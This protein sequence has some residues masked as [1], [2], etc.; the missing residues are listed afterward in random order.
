MILTFGDL[1]H[2]T[3]VRFSSTRGI[4]NCRCSASFK[5][6]ALIKLCCILIRNRF[7]I[8]N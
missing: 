6:L 1:C 8:G 5:V 3:P 4:V 2:R 7:E